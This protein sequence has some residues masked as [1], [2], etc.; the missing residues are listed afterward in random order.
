ML[1]VKVPINFS[2]TQGFPARRDGRYYLLERSSEDV[3]KT[4]HTQP[5]ASL[6]HRFYYIIVGLDATTKGPSP[7]V[8]ES[9]VSRE[10]KVFCSENNYFTFLRILHTNN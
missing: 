6:R 10:S 1:K 3:G 4:R 5:H 7:L 9:K 2:G 8:G